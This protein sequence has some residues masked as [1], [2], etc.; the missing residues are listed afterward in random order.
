MSLTAMDWMMTR[1][2]ANG[3]RF[4]ADVRAAFKGLADVNDKRYDSR[5]GLGV[6]YRWTPR[7]IEQLCAK[8]HVTPQIHRS[9]FERIA[10]NTEGY[11]P[12]GLPTEL[13]IVSTS[14]P[15]DIRDRLAAIVADAFKPGPPLVQR[16]GSAGSSSGRPDTPDDP[17]HGDHR[18]AD[19][20]EVREGQPQRRRELA[21][22]R[23]RARGQRVELALAER[24]GQHGLALS[25]GR[26]W[27]ARRSLSWSGPI[28]CWTRPIRPSGTTS[29]NGCGSP[30]ECWPSWFLVVRPLRSWRSVR[31]PRT[32][33]QG[34]TK[35]QGRTRNQEPCT[36]ERLRSA[37]PFA[38]RRLSR[39]APSEAA[40][41]CRARCTRTARRG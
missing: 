15:P 20:G 25:L 34:R 38:G 26:F 22:D 27:L 28:T 41:A 6:F 32:T 7:D 16:T 35:D 9:V 13:R 17:H 11:A 36:K 8:C 18:G 30:C 39:Q 14:A 29:G 19:A 23:G 3:L 12:G 33:D 31:G 1:A 5:A 10:R 21:A 40:G 4:H 37:S 24:H 2:E